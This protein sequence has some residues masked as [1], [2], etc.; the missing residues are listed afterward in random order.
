MKNVAPIQLCQ[1]DK[2]NLSP[3][4]LKI[5]KVNRV[6]VK[7]VLSTTNPSVSVF[8]PPSPQGGYAL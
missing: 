7:I 4:P 5:T 3:L 2:I 6:I 8:T 1:F